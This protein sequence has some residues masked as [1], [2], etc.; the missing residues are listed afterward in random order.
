[1][2]HTLYQEH[3]QGVSKLT[4]KQTDMKYL[5]TAVTIFICIIQISCSK[6]LL[7]KTDPTRVG[8]ETFFKDETEL[9]QG[10][11]GVYSQLQ[12]ITRGAFVYKEMPSDNTTLQI[13][14][15]NRGGAVGWETLE[16]ATWNSGTGDMAGIWRN[17]YSTLY[18]VNNVLEKT[19]NSDIAADIKAQTEGELKFLRAYLYF[20]L[21]RYFGDVVLVTQNVKTPDEAFD[22]IRSSQAD[23]Y[24]QI[25]NDLKDALASLPGNQPAEKTGRATKGAALCM[26]GEVYLTNK[27]YPDAVNTLKQVLS[28]GYSLMPSYADVFDPAK[29][30]NAESIFE[31]QYQGDND[32]GEWSSFEYSF[33]PY[34]SG[35]AVTGYDV[36]TLGGQ[37]IPTNDIIAAYEPGDL[38][39]NVSL[40]TGYT[41]NGVYNAIPYVSKYNHPHTIKG[42]TN[43]NW[44]VY[45]YADVLLMLA[46]AINE[47]DGNG[48]EALGYLNLVRTR[49]GLVALAGLDRAAFRTAVLHER[50][51]ELAFENHRWFDLKRTKTPAELAAF[52][53]AHG[54]REKAN[55]TCDRGGVAF[56]AQDY[57]YTDNE[58]VF[59]I[60]ASEILINSNLTQN[61]GY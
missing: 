8:T 45:R 29:K 54:V 3:L 22:L 25:E 55:P 49:A 43:D 1:M 10:V 46:E 35:D 38:R 30:N 42:R 37:N 51:I 31:I 48:A 24:T 17:Y 58:Y 44:P 4:S 47:D 9:D 33:A 50:R 16:Y 19:A 20:D 61:S 40:Q 6:S 41:K 60:P 13:N 12:D 21:V 2:K 23:V 56:N 15:Q 7:E 26:L 34:L 14:P 57:V 36:G 27:R 59:P 39:K 28:L 5:L 52:M 18:N 53:N 11:N 32:L